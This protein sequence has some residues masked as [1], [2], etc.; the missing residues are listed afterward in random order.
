MTLDKTEQILSIQDIK[1]LQEI[2]KKVYLDES[3]K[4]YIVEIINATR[5]ADKF[6]S[7]DLAKYITTGAST[8][9]TIAFM[10][11]AKATALIRGRNYVIPDDVKSIRYDILRHRIALNYTA[12]ADSVKV[13]TIIDAIIGAIKT[14]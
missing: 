10:D 2:C 6:I 11:A 4:K 9:G 8:R 12:I 14:P 5:N 7:Q 13:E 3:I 1:F